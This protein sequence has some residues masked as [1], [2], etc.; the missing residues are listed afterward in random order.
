MNCVQCLQNGYHGIN[1]F[2]LFDAICLFVLLAPSARLLVH[3]RSCSIIMLCGAYFS[4][5]LGSSSTVAKI[6]PNIRCRFKLSE[7]A[8][9]HSSRCHSAGRRDRTLA[10]SAQLVLSKAS[11]SVLPVR[12]LRSVLAPL[13]HSPGS[14]YFPSL[15]HPS[16]CRAV[17]LHHSHSSLPLC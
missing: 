10:V 8:V 15:D 5:G 14:H 2:V 16:A 6:S 4:H 11:A 1:C 3:L 12:Q 13:V 7:V 17:A 9:A